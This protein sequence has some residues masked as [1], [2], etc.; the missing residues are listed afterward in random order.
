[1]ALDWF[2][3]TEAKKFG[4]QLAGLF[5]ERTTP[6]APL[7]GSKRLKQKIN[8][9]DHKVSQQIGAFKQQNRLNVYKTAQIGVK[10]KETLLTEGFDE[11]YVA[12]LTHWLMYKIKGQS[13]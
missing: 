4:V 13:R 5:I 12:E 8:A 6:D 3:A 2:D 7:P 1:M 9:L 10:F 11:D